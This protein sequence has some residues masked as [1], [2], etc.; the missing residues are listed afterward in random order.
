MPSDVS[1]LPS[2][3][4]I[5]YRTLFDEDEDE[6]IVVVV[7]DVVDVVDVSVASDIVEIVA[8]ELNEL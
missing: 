8:L 3:T 5:S 6:F 4:C 2:T 1:A 7:V